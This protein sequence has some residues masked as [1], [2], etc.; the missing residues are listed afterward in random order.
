[1]E[2]NHTG[3]FSWKY[4][5]CRVNEGT[6][7]YDLI[8]PNDDA[9]SSL[10]LIRPGIFASFDNLRLMVLSARGSSSVVHADHPLSKTRKMEKGGVRKNDTPPLTKF[11]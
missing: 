7:W 3:T 8:I 1:M 2:T 9:F 11:G 6:T 10:P 4:P 5:G